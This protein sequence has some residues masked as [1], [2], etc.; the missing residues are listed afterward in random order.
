MYSAVRDLKKELGK[1]V[2]FIVAN[3][4]NDETLKLAELYGV[5]YVP[6]FIVFDSAGNIAARK[7]GAM[8]VE[9]LRAM[10][11]R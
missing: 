5:R 4:K 9:E 2:E 6:D 11:L 3:F 7:G 8:S 1:E 10:A